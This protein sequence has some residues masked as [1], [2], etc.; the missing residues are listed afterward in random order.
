MYEESTC[1]RMISTAVCAAVVHI[2]YDELYCTAEGRLL[3]DSSASSVAEVREL[4][5][6][7][8]TRTHYYQ[9]G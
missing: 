9:M 2:L 6:T 4:E 5:V 1:R 7:R 3:V 8:T